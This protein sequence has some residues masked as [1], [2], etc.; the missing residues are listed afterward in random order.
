M[1]LVYLGEE[2]VVELDG[3]PSDAGSSGPE[4]GPGSAGPGPHQGPRPSTAKPLK[5]QPSSNG[6]SAAGS[7]MPGAGGHGRRGATATV[8]A[9]AAAAT[10]G[11][12][13][14]TPAVQTDFW[15]AIERLYPLKVR[16]EL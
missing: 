13:R 8:K 15:G 16:W 10:E 6:R 12:E 3:A 4:A 7:P 11:E 9:G 2:Q 14:S 5:G 1:Q